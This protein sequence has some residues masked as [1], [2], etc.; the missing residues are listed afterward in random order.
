MNPPAFLQ[1]CLAR[2][3]GTLPG[4]VIRKLGNLVRNVELRTW[5]K[6]NGVALAPAKLE[7]D[8]DRFSQCWPYS[9]SV[10]QGTRGTGSTY[11]QNT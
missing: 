5:M 10:H 11:A 2:A 7:G 6:R 1:R 9:T 8:S 3:G 4:S